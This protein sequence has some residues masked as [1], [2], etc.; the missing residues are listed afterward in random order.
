MFSFNDNRPKK[1]V[2][3]YR[4]SGE[5]KQE[6]SVSI[7]RDHA[8]QFVRENNMEIIHEE[9]DEGKTGLT[10]DR[11]A[12]MR[13]LTNWV[14][15][16]DAPHFD[17]VLVL[18]VSRWG[19]YQ[20]MD[21]PAYL[22]Y[23]C[24]QHGKQVIYI[25]YGV[26]KEGSELSSHLQINVDRYMAAE[27]SKVLSEKVFH[28]SM[29]VSRQGY[30]AGGTACY[31]MTR[32]LLNEQKEPVRVLKPGEQKSIA[33]ERVTFAPANDATTQVVKDIFIMFVESQKMPEE[34]AAYLNDNG[35]PS[36]G[37]FQWTRD[38]IIKIL[39]N[40]TYVG[41]RVYNKT[42]G[43]L[44]KKSH[45]NPRSEWVIQPNAFPGIVDLAMFAQ[46][47]ERLY[48]ILPSRKKR[49]IYMKRRM[50]RLVNERVKRFFAEQNLDEVDIAIKMLELPVLFSVSLPRQSGVEWCFTIPE[51]IR[52][53][54][55]VLAIC[56]DREQRDMVDQVFLLP[57]DDF[58]A[59]N[60][61]IF[62]NRDARFPR[63]Q[64]REEEVEEKLLSVL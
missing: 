30:S 46:A 16:P 26:P 31:G 50:Q 8:Q 64:V 14:E 48:Q 39:D 35:I 33:N 20:N 25:K 2:A 5:N 63:Y 40:E 29:K 47:Q 34:I 6:N 1:A 53:N 59:A 24:S 41:T 60:L 9:A 4:H 51:K 45:R 38:K 57:T 3:Y 21:E 56:V 62:S 23:R 7:Q 18:D 54:E 13:L 27:Y 52:R 22:Q 55:H 19:R 15:N 12:F 44:K 58:G 11:P 17:Y 32:I 43:R 49:G 42:W 28:G 37:G 61:M 36:A 10:S